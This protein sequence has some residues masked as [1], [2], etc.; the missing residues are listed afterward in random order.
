MRTCRPMEREARPLP[1][2]YSIQN[3]L[4]HLRERKKVAGGDSGG[5]IEWLQMSWERYRDKLTLW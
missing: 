3:A 4:R 1:C 5:E 2:V